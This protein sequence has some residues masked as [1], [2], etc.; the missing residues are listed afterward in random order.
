M[1]HVRR[2]YCKGCACPIL[3]AVSI[4][5]RPFPLDPVTKGTGTVK[6]HHRPEPMSPIAEI[7]NTGG[8]HAPHRES[9]AGPAA[10]NW[11]A[12]KKART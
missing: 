12:R 8:D 9:C 3:W 10:V 1:R 5:G 11:R 6:L 7:V 2:G 4:T